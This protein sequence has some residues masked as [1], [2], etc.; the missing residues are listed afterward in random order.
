MPLKIREELIKILKGFLD[1]LTSQIKNLITT[2]I[3]DFYENIPNIN[4]DGLMGEFGNQLRNQFKSSGLEL[5]INKNPFDVLLFKLLIFIGGAVFNDMILG[6][7]KST[8]DIK[9]SFIDSVKESFE[10]GV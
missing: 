9:T 8:D 7:F 2:E 1:T 4:L 5:L 3:K 6:T 10:K